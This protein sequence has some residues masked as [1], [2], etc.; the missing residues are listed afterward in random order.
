M[1]LRGEQL[2]VRRFFVQDLHT[3]H[4]LYIVHDLHIVQ[5]LQI[6]KGLHIVQDLHITINNTENN[7][8]AKK[9]REALGGQTQ[10]RI[11]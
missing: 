10:A 1:E 3:V 5:D 9:K 8:I 4:N 2:Q 6:V 11:F 7:A